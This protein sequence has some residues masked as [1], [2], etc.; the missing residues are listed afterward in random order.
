[1]A[2]LSRNIPGSARSG[3]LGDLIARGLALHR[4]KRLKEAEFCYQNVLR[5]DPD[6]P[7]AN[8]LMGTL[9]A[10]ARKA[11]MAVDYFK[12]AVT[13]T[14]AA[15]H[16]YRNNLGNAYLMAN[17]PELALVELQ[18][19]VRRQ[20]RLYPALCNLG[21]AY[22]KL[23]LADQGL[24]YLE[25]AMRLD[26]ERPDARIALAE[27]LID[28]G[29]MDEAA[30][31][32]REILAMMP[33]FPEALAGLAS[34]RKFKADDPEIAQIERLIATGSLNEA[35]LNLLH[36][37]A[38]KMCNDAKDHDRAYEHFAK[39][40]A[41]AGKDFDLAAYRRRVDGLIE[42]FT[43][44]FFMER[45]EAFGRSSEVP[46]FIVGMPRSGTTLTEQIAASHPRIYGAGELSHMRHMAIDLNYESSSPG[47]LTGMRDMSAR[48]SQDLADDYLYQITKTGGD[49]MR[50]IDKMPH[51]FEL[52][53]LVA[54]LFPRARIIHCR[55][56]P[57]DN[58]VSCFTNRFSE[59]HGYNTDLRQLGAYYRE[60][61]RLMDH[62]RRV[63]PLPMLEIDYQ[64]M[65]DDQETQSRRLI[66]FLGLDWDPA[67]LDFH[68]T[69][70][71]VQTISR[72]QVRQPIYK[73]S[74]KRWKDYEK[75][76]G[77]LK[78]A[79]GDLAIE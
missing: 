74:V 50:I 14:K 49:A 39:G 43:P 79:L 60:Y 70:R 46:V 37:A 62:W 54:L 63:L 56:D 61:K 30:A 22:R 59:N 35:R 9:A 71:T 58:C 23:N 3:V 20:P 19:V 42:T 31:L 26:P 13:A 32:Y 53:G 68:K 17:R 29:R 12:R 10:E 28:L 78:E 1:M 47:F 11:A 34:T 75:H 55:R 66:D 72:W 73:T 8:N 77:P 40:K 4:Q 57:L 38:G 67:C 36:H 65:I 33:D 44:F 16:V 41:I 6:H 76:I 5:Q 21:R 64:E 25:K 2:Q 69:E 27:S 18:W 7:E 15:N 48:K 45:R 52:L 24:A 51:N